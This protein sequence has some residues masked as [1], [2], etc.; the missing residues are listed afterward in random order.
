MFLR[1]DSRYATKTTVCPFG[2]TAMSRVGNDIGAGKYIVCSGGLEFRHQTATTISATAKAQALSHANLSLP[3]AVAAEGAV[4]A[5]D[6]PLSPTHFSSLAR[7]LAFC[8]RSSGAFARHFFT[9]W[10]SAS[11]VIGLMEQI[12]V[13][14]FS[15]MAE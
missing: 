12:G 11:G 14:S 15:R 3:F 8:H 4:P 1:L 5:V 6:P 7:S 2:A 10:S 9:A 13:G